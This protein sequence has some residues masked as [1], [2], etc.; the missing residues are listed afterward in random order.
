MAARTPTRSLLAAARR[1]R[2]GDVVPEYVGAVHS[3]T[4]PG[5]EQKF[6]IPVASNDQVVSAKRPADIL[7]RPATSDRLATELATPIGGVPD[8]V[9]PGR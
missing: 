1:P 4:L 8:A 2:P 9:Q 7:D 5:I 3:W 6:E